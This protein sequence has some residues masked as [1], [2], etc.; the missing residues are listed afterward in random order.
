MPG[1]NRQPAEGPY[2]APRRPRAGAAAWAWRGGQRYRAIDGGAGH[3][4]DRS[5]AKTSNAGRPGAPPCHHHLTLSRTI[6]PGNHVTGRARQRSHTNAN[7]ATPCQDP[8]RSDTVLRRTQHPQSRASAVRPAMLQPHTDHPFCT[9]QLA[10]A[11]DTA[12]APQLGGYLR[13]CITR[14]IT[15]GSRIDQR[16]AQLLSA[17]QN[18]RP[19]AATVAR[20]PA[21]REMPRAFRRSRAQARQNKLS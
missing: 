12:V 4:P 21:E 2:R 14:L 7:H 19:P 16:R 1:R 20:L 8:A 13:V 18:L 10:V 17:R 9:V 3:Y 15:D 11:E 6:L 5:K